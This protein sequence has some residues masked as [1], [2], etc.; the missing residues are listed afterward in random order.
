[1]RPVEPARAYSQ[2]KRSRQC[3]TKQCA[4]VVVARCR[5]RPFR[6]SRRMAQRSSSNAGSRGPCG[7]Y[8]SRGKSRVEN[9]KEINVDAYR[10]LLVKVVRVLVPGI[11]VLLCSPGALRAQQQLFVDCSGTNPYVYPSINAALQNAGPGTSIFVTGTCNESISLFGQNAFNL[12]A[13]FGQTATI[14]GG[15]SINK[16]E[17]VF[18]YGLNVT[19]PS[20]DGI[21]VGNSGGIV[22]DNCNST[23]NAGVGLNVGGMSDVAVTSAG[24]FDYNIR[25]GMIIGGNS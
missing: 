2:L 9:G 24:T 15:I 20:G 4:E 10:K 13:F 6:C 12:G 11:L 1:M 8:L 21:V 23:G 7:A 14:N 25:G 3:T 22:V 19:N 17:N 5:L 16:S 18:L